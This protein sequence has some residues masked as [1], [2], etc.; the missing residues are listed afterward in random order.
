MATL[1]LDYL[2]QSKQK[3]VTLKT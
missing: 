2:Q 3:Q 1:T